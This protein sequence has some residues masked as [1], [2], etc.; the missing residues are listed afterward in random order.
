M[1][2]ISITIPVSS[3]GCERTFFCLRRLKTYMRNKMTDERL[4]NLSMTSIENK[5]AK[6]LD[7][8]EVVDK[9]AV[10]HNNRKIILV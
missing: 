10:N 6:S 4:S 1:A 7:L 9:F 8:E 3:A 2:I 5:I